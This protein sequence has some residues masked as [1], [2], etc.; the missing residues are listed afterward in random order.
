MVV[1]CATWR[2]ARHV[3]DLVC[4]MMPQYNATRPKP[5]LLFGASG[6][7]DIEVTVYIKTHLLTFPQLMAHIVLVTVYC[8]LDN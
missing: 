8:V 5:I 6:D 3:Y 7:R 1:L 4:Q 2:T